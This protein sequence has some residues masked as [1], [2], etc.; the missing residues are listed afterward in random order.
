MGRTSDLRSLRATIGIYLLGLAILFIGGTLTLLAW[1]SAWRAAQSRH[2]AEFDHYVE[3]ATATVRNRISTYTTLVQAGQ[4]LFASSDSVHRLEWRAF[5]HSLDFPNRFEGVQGLF[6]IS[7]VPQ[8]QL[9]AFLRRARADHSPQFGLYPA[10]SRNFYCPLTYNEPETDDSKAVGFDACSTPNGLDVLSR[11]RDRG[12][13]TLSAP[14]HIPDAN[15]VSRIGVVLVAPVYR[16]GADTRDIARRRTALRGWTGVTLPAN[17][18]MDGVIPGQAQMEMRVFDGTAL[19]PTSAIYG[20]ADSTSHQSPQLAMKQIILNADGRDWTL[21]F[22]DHNPISRIPLGVAVAGSLITLL[23][24]LA[25]V[26][27]GLTRQR[28]M[29]LARRMTA[30]LRD[31]QQL[32]SSITNNISDGIYRSSLE[33]GLIYV[34]DALARMFGYSTA[35]ELMSVPGPILYVNPRRREELQVM[36][37]ENLEYHDQEVEYQRKDGSRFHGMNS[38]LA[39]HDENG[40][41]LYFDGVISDI[42]ERKQAERQVYRLAHYDTLTGLP[43]RSH[44]RDRLEQTLVDAGRRKERLAIMFL[45]MDR[46]KNVNDSLGHEIGDLLLQA[47]SKRLLEC[48]RRNDSVSRQGGDEFIVVLRDIADE[49]A[50]AHVADKILT[51]V[52]GL[53][54]IGTHEMHITPSIGISLFPDDGSQVEDLIRNADTAMY[55]AKENGRANYQFF[56]PEMIRRTHERLS[57]EGELRHAL[58]RE[59]FALVYQPQVDMRSGEIAGAEALLRWNNRNLGMISPATFIPIA[60]QSGLIVPIGEWVLQTTCRQNRA[61]LDAGL[62]PIP[63]AVNLSA[64]QFRRN[65]MAGIIAGILAQSSLDPMLLEL[66]LTESVIMQETRETADMM[67]RLN[68]LG[69]R[70]SIDDFGTGYSSLSY[71]KRFRIDKLKIDQSFVRDITT[72]PDDAAIISAIISLGQSLNVKI[73]AEGAETRE[74]LEFL[75]RCQCDLIQGYHFSKPL[76]ADEFARLLRD[77]RRMVLETL[78]ITSD[79]IEAGA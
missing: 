56:T 27:L 70:L 7:Y 53:Y 50:A 55:Q 24:T 20:A 3:Q 5:A 19:K 44:L 60:E 39:I 10:G 72:D 48:V 31:K 18:I 23:L 15:G 67:R 35:M 13:P 43:N 64:I 51:T 14:L 76:P 6:Y 46:F 58:E 30:E 33:S 26:N 4:G 37:E 9:S 45:D 40:K 71:L 17:L 68:Q 29:I 8:P 69:V 42:T 57:L 28:A 21:Q 65:D 61:W 34:N 54:I 63:V 66:E 49:A 11:A 73:V 36:L 62:T 38:A 41:V 78:E 75:H 2:E 16:K 32:L 79:R 74:Q 59:E 52:G 25:I 1:H 77:G 47:V 12:E 22:L